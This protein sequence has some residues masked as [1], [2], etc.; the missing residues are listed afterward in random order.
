[1][2]TKWFLLGVLTVGLALA[3]GVGLVLAE[4]PTR[5]AASP[6]GTA[7][8]YQGY[9]TKNDSPVRLLRGQ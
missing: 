9:L 4:G 6:V 8:T 1:M 2:K 5:P 7:F 3:V